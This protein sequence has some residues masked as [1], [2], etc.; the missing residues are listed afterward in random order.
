M[1]NATSKRYED[2]A[3]RYRKKS[4]YKIIARNI[5]YRFGEIDIVAFEG[6]TM[7]FVEVKGGRSFRLPRYRVDERKLRR[8]ELA[9]QRYIS[10][11][12]P[13]FSETRLDVI[14]VLNDGEVNH[15]KAV[16]RW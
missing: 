15:L 11:E 2:I 13:T 3:C 4:G 12:K 9:A 6:R 10:T 5:S 14:E 16:G 7:V 8:L 1:S